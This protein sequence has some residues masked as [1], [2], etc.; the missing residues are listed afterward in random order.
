VLDRT[1]LRADAVARGG[2]QG[3]SQLA[4]L[5]ALERLVESLSDAPRR[6][7]VADVARTLWSLG[8]VGFRGDAGTAA[9]RRGVQVMTVHQS[10]GL[11]FDAVYV[12]G[13][14]RYNWPG[15]ERGG[16][17]IPDALLPETVP[18][19]PDAHTWEAR[20]LAYVALTRARHTLVLATV[21]QSAAGVPQRPSAFLDDV[22]GVLPRLELRPVGDDPAVGLAERVGAARER[23]ERATAAQA[24]AEA[25][26]ST[27][28][29]ERDETV[30]AV[31]DLVA[32]QSAALRREPVVVPEP[33]PPPPVPGVRTAVS[34]LARYWRCPLQYRYA[35]VDR[36][37]GV[38]GDPL[39]GLGIATHLT[40]EEGFAP[41]R[42]PMDAE[43]MTTLLAA[44]CEAE[45]V[46]GTAQGR[47]AIERSRETFPDMVRVHRSAGT[48]VVAT[49]KKFTLELHPHRL[50]G[51][52]DR[53]DL[54]PDGGYVL[55]DYKTG[56]QPTGNAARDGHVVMRLYML[57]ADQALG[58][59]ARSAVL[60]YVFDGDQSRESPEQ[61]DMEEAVTVARESLDA[62]AAGDFT[63]TPGWVCRSCDYRLI[64]PAQDR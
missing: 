26:G 62:I 58:V 43:A 3:A 11:E 9:E 55:V 46:A 18:A 24:R 39:R 16:V 33:P 14:T 29:A 15:R 12:I 28:D 32:A 1:G 20:R 52:I 59:H 54:M 8:E 60:A 37:P 45:G 51:R 19:D 63:P 27:T 50:T 48:Q 22:M 61:A 30:A 21:G 40:L 6:P 36:I 4:A 31:A 38:S 49:E 47:H 13:L 57:G 35:H 17:D 41:G 5:A 2:A 25:D 7:G 34:A 10:K 42:E 23:L 53:I 44:R 56:N 64:C